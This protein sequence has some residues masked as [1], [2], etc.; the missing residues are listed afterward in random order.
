MTPKPQRVKIEKT[1]YDEK[2]DTITWLVK[3][4]DGQEADLVWT[5][6]DFGPTFRINALIPVSLVKEFNENMLGKEVNL[7]VEPKP[8]I[9][10]IDYEQAKKDIAGGE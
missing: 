8:Q 10:E 9:P 5:R 4:S 6:E 1:E 3:L 2:S 7:I